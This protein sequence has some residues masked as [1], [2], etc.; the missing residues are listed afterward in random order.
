MLLLLQ[1]RACTT[2]RPF[3]PLVSWE[4]TQVGLLTPADPSNAADHTASCS[5]IKLEG[6]LAEG[7]LFG[8][9]MASVN[10]FFTSLVFLEFYFSLFVIFTAVW[11]LL[12]LLLLQLLNHSYLNP[13]IFSHSPF[14]FTSLILLQQDVTKC[15][16]GAQLLAE[17][18]PWHC[19]F[20]QRHFF[21]PHSK[22]QQ[23][24]LA[25]ISLRICRLF[26][27]YAKCTFLIYCLNINSF[28]VSF[29]IHTRLNIQKKTPKPFCHSEVVH[30]RLHVWHT[31]MFKT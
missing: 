4:G 17:V 14:Q 16:C 18:E 12:L 23:S 29:H 10:S 24:V 7:T 22:T 20:R 26:P 21:F 1:S 3:L 6:M 15:L 2:S 8:D 9:K 11:L 27:L 5:A 19:Y 25:Q 13:L 28:E 31:E 30:E